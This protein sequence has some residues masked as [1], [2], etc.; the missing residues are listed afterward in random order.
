[1]AD[2]RPRAEA[3]ARREKYRSAESPAPPK[4]ECFENYQTSSCFVFG[5]G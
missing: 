5:D 4:T 3:K 2:N 1:M